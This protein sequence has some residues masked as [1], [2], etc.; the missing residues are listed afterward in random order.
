[1]RTAAAPNATQRS[2]RRHHQNSCPAKLIY[3]IS[4]CGIESSRILQDDLV[5]MT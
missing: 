1:L 3:Q 5:A 4:D 2:R